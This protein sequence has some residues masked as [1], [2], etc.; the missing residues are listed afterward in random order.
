MQKSSKFTYCEGRVMLG[1]KSMALLLENGLERGLVGHDW[2][3][4]PP[5]NTLSINFSKGGGGTR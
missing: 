3:T 4:P 2:E 5:F 1:S